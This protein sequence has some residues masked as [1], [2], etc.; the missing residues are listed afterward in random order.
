MR[1]NFL[2][3]AAALGLLAGTTFAQAPV[4]TPSQARA[5]ELLDKTD[6]MHRGESSHST[7]TMHVKTARWDRTL[8]IEG[9]AQG[10][11]MSLMKI[12]APAK[13][14]GMAT[15]KV[16]DNIWNYLPKVDRTM[17]VP[18]G[19]MSGSWMGSHFTN[20]DLVKESRMA[21]DYTFD[22]TAEPAADGT[23]E[24]VVECVPKPDAPVVWGKLVVKLR[25]DEQPTEIT[26]WDEKGALVRTMSFS[27]YREVGGH[28]IAGKMTLVPADEPDE[29]TEV[30]YEEIEFGVAIPASTFTLQA[31]K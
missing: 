29:F 15:L 8:T 4:E 23:G 19:M 12:L 10:E 7:V 5:R 14:A 1:R 20:D 13:E 2:T 6:D 16:E 22:L 11:D 17:K 9:W 24:Y 31:L 30:I 25:A 18:A 28:L 3:I 26:Y 21:D 27:D